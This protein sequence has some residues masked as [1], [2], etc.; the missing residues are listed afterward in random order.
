MDE[1]LRKVELVSNELGQT[2]FR[3][4]GA[5][6]L[7]RWHSIRGHQ[8]DLPRANTPRVDENQQKGV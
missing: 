3:V 8:G 4:K 5:S 1:F 7:Q 6:Y 2:H